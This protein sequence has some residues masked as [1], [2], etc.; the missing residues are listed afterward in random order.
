MAARRAP[1]AVITDVLMPGLDG[2]ELARALRGEPATRHIPIVFSTAHY[3]RQEIQPLAHACGVHDVILKPARPSTVLATIDSLFVPGP[4]SVPAVEQIVETQ[5]L[6]RCGTWELDLATNTIL[7]S[8]ELSDVLRVPSKVA[9]HELT[10]RMHPDDVAAIATMVENT[11]C[12]GSPA[13][14]ELRVVDADGSVRELIVSCRTASAHRSSPAARLWGVAQD[15]TQIREKLR[16]SLQTQVDW[17]AVRRTI[18]AFHRA[19]LPSTLPAIAGAGLATVYLPDPERLDIGT[20]WYDAHPVAGGRLLVS[21]G[22]VAGHDRHPV[23]VMGHALAALRTYAHDDPD[24]VGVLTRLNRFLA[25]TCQDDTFVTAVVG[26]FDPA[27][28]H[29]RV[30]NGGHP[31]PLVLARDGDGD[32]GVS[33]MPVTA[34]GPALGVLADAVFPHSDLYLAPGSAFCAYTEGLTDRHNDPMSVG[35]RRLRRVAAQVFG[36]FSPAEQPGDSAAADFLAENIV[37][38]ML[39][40]AAPDDDV[41]LAVLYAGTGDV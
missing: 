32:D 37:R 40:G 3:G 27:T 18:D 35:G 12:T 34:A 21:V 10:R 1:D 38:D 28:G 33:A 15:V 11:W 36:R 6:T 8:P 13:T 30:A 31:A 5:R 20:A 14:A 24:P 2:Y 19:V 39:A 26:L 41:C 7:V 17:H 25:D 9:V 4:I 16:T 23:A 29:L 22:K